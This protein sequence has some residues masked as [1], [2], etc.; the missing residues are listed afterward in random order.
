MAVQSATHQR[1]ALSH[2]FKL[3]FAQPSAGAGN[4]ARPRFIIYRGTAT[5]TARSVQG[6]LRHL[7]TGREPRPH[8]CNEV[9]RPGAAARLR[10]RRCTATVALTS[11]G[12]VQLKLDVDLIGHE[13]HRDALAHA[14]QGQRGDGWGVGSCR[15]GPVQ[16]CRPA[17]SPTLVAPV[18]HRPSG[19]T[20]SRPLAFRDRPR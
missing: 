3:P 7:T 2:R 5:F 11:G 14:S 1:R 18:A 10:Q 12:S 17:S 20:S 9:S 16:P 19:R 6:P 13:R 8:L 15:V 4:A